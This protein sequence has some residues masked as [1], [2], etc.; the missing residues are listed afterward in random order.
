[1]RLAS[2]GDE[3][4]RWLGGLYYLNIDREVGVNTGIDS[5]TG[6]TKSLYV[7]RG[8]PNATEQL[9]WD[10]FKSDVY[11][12]FANL[13]Y[14]VTDQFE[15]SLALRYDSEKRKVKN[16]VPTRR[17]ARPTSTTTRSTTPSSAMRR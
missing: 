10:N 15:A 6:I 9:V 12:G 7:P 8:Q 2:S 3:R 14:D 16:L 1:M 13:A 11:A 4:L 5:G 17:R